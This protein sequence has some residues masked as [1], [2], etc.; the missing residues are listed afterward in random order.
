M[1]LVKTLTGSYTIGFILLAA[2][3]VACLIVLTSLDRPPPRRV[4]ALDPEAPTQL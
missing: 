2:V 3:A 4:A 1:A